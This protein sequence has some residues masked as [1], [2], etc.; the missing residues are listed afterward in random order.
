MGNCHGSAVSAADPSDAAVQ[1]E[2]GGVPKKQP[3]STATSATAEEQ[4]HERNDARKGVRS[5][6]PPPAETSA[7]RAD[8]RS[9]SWSA[10]GW[11]ASLSLHGPVLAAIA[12]PASVDAFE[13]FRTS[14]TREQLEAQLKEARLDGMTE[15]VWAAIAEL[16]ERKAATGAALS[17]KFAQ[18]KEASF[19]MNFGSLDTFFGG[20]EGL[21]G[22]PTMIDASLLKAME[23]E[24]C[25]KG[26]CD[27][28]FTTSN[29]MEDVTSKEEWEF[30]V[31]PEDGKAYKERGGGF[32]EEHPEWCR[33]AIPL[34]V[35][36]KEMERINAMLE[37][38]KHTP[39]V[40]EELVGG[41]LYTGPVRARWPP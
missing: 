40:I 30:V 21:I 22:T 33:R 24:H 20:L 23:V 38:K 8:E 29:G 9:A 36:E 14:L 1:P 41:R 31:E 35:Y 25:G 39:M 32:R 28:P 19:E 13:Y 26:D 37:S 27:M 7:E 17:A 5:D 6:A 16:R 2:Q 11:L 10:A 18:D 4:Q 12:P 34:D 15:I 3:Q